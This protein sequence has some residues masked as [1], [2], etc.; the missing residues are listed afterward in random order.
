[1]KIIERHKINSPTKKDL[2]Y[3]IGLFDTATLISEENHNI[4]DDIY[5]QTIR[6]QI[7]NSYQQNGEDLNYFQNEIISIKNELSKKLL[8]NTESKFKALYNLYLYVNRLDKML[9][10]LN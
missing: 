6:H 5:L 1:M 7:I 3:F 8:T 9:N 10:C 2:E 4:E